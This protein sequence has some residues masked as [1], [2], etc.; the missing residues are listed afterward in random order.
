VY[1]VHFNITILYTP[2]QTITHN[3]NEKSDKTL[4]ILLQFTIKFVLKILVQHNTAQ[5]ILPSALF[6]QMC[7]YAPPNATKFGTICPMQAP[8]VEQRQPFPG[9]MLG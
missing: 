1:S 6:P 7:S 4:P 2:E 3:S 5:S 9:Q 8:G